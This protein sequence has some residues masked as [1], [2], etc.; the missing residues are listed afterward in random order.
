M[1]GSGVASSLIHEAGHQAAALLDLNE[2][3]RPFL[4]GMIAASRRERA[5]WQLWDRWIAEIVA[6][7]WSV[8]QI[9]IGSTLGLLSVVSLPRAF[10]FRGSLDDPHPSPWIRVKLS[11]E[12]GNALY[13]DRQWAR[14]S[15][16][17]E[18]FYPLDELPERQQ[19]L[20]RLLEQTI[21]GLV[22]MI[23][24]HRPAALRGQMLKD[25]L[26]VADRQ[27]ET[28]RQ[29]IQRWRL[30]PAEMYQA[31]PTLAFAVIG[32]G[33]SDGSV[34][35]EEESVVLGKLLTHWAL[36]STLESAASCA[37]RDQSNAPCGCRS[38]AAAAG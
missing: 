1:V 20:L 9:G 23:V 21:P 19:T 16:T 7:F 3:L 17:W 25:V 31:R 13:P 10:V 29:F 4:R 14:L 2:S 6:D 8:G 15:E 11:A 28:L 38:C 37:L 33:R 22:A 12:M 34:S 26:N 30:L 32:Q 18:S 5:A 24:N 35:P 36:Q 27:P